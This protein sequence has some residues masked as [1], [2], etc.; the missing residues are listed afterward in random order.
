[1]LSP[2]PSQVVFPG[3]NRPLSQASLTQVSHSRVAGESMVTFLPA[4][5]AMRPP[6][7]CR[8]DMLTLASPTLD[9]ARPR[10]NTGGAFTAAACS[11]SSSQ[12]LGASV[13]PLGS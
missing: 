2:P 5:S 3:G 13:K 8:M 12:V 7:D 9:S 10:P 4:S 1:M 11:L 6:Y